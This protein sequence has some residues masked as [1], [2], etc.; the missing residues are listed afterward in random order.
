MPLAGRLPGKAEVSAA[1][2]HAIRHA[3]TSDVADAE[4]LDA[5][6]DW[7]RVEPFQF[8]LVKGIMEWPEPVD[9]TPAPKPR[10]ARGRRRG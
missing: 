8:G 4:V 1:V 5:R 3:Q 2:F 7:L 10:A 9:L 6:W